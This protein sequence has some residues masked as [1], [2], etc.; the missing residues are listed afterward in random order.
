[1]FYGQKCTG[2]ENCTGHQ[3]C[4]GHQK[5]TGTKNIQVTKDALVTKNAQVTKARWLLEAARQNTKDVLKMQ[6]RL[7]DEVWPCVLVVAFVHVIHFN[8]LNS[9]N[10]PI[11]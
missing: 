1:M 4:A 11:I 7:L 10:D 2:H 8:A 6:K 5:Y 9:I 3:K